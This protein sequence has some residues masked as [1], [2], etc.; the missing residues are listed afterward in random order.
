MNVLCNI[1]EEK[2]ILTSSSGVMGDPEAV[3]GG[4]SKQGASFKAVE[5]VTLTAADI[6]GA[7]LSQPLDKHP[8]VALRWWLLCRGTKVPTSLKKK[9]LIDRLA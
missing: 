4:G 2:S 9:E 1:E 7:E 6:P 5:E 3:T 8:V